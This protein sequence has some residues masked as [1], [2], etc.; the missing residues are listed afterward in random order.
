[1][2]APT[3]A[4]RLGALTSAAVALAIAVSACGS[5]SGGAA[6]AAAASGSSGSSG[7]SGCPS[8]V[9]AD[10]KAV[11]TAE[12]PSTTWNGPTTG[13]KAVSGKYI[14]FV[15][16]TLQN[17]GVL[18]V[19]QGFRQAAK[20]LGWTV[21]VFDGQNSTPGENSAL[22]AAIDSKPAAIA[23]V[24]FP[25]ILVKP[26]VKQANTKHIPLIGWHATPIAGP[27]DGLF[28]DVTSLNT[29]I[30][31]IAGQYAVVAQKGHVHAVIMTDPSIPETLQ[32]AQGMEAA[33]KAC[34]TSSVLAVD[35]VPF[36]DID[37]QSPT[38][39]SAALQKYGSKLTD[40][41]AINDLA[42]DASVPSLESASISATGTPHLIAAGDGSTSAFQR[43]RKSQY[44]TATVAEPLLMHG[45]Q[46]AD[47]INRALAHAKPSGYVTTPH[48]VTVEDVNDYDG[49][50][51]IFNPPNGYAA[52]YRK[53]WNP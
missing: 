48:L 32:K 42:F 22:S 2:Q 33:I 39:V 41:F 35:D 53:I 29:A 18:G 49:Q 46:V 24:G 23:I 12:H 17:G 15:G 9:A 43:I 37:S 16:G 27:G 21:K 52:A 20:V 14:A 38:A 50:A 10:T 47:E 1:M 6:T 7:S 8:V 40:I 31:K 28:S 5:S 30:G 45:W 25:S 26:E 11:Y 13:P 34:S 51:G 36:E 3:G 44:Q 19:L 4:R